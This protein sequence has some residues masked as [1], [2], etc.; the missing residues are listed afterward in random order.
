MTV[1]K[2]ID[3]ST[4]IETANWTPKARRHG[5]RVAWT[6]PPQAAPETSEEIVPAPLSPP[7]IWPRV[8][9]GI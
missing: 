1:G 2:L 3:R 6:Q 8:F 7:P 5:E 4:E 9:P